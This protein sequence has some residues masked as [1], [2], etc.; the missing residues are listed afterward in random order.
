MSQKKP[1]LGKFG[2]TRI[3]EEILAIRGSCPSFTAI[4]GNCTESPAAKQRSIREN[5]LRADSHK[6]KKVFI[7]FEKKRWVR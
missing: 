7:F 5:E 2:M 4:S 1:G 6:A 3:A